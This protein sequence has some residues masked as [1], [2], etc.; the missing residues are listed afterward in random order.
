MLE[1]TIAVSFAIL[2]SFFCSILE[3]ALYAI[4]MGQVEALAE[5]GSRTGRLLK[6]FRT[7]VDAPISAI[8]ALNTV[9]HT[10]GA[11]VAGAAAAEVFGKAWLSTFSLV[12]TLVVLIFSEIIPK[13]AGYVYARRIAPALA[14]R[15]PRR[16]TQHDLSRRSLRWARGPEDGEGALFTYEIVIVVTF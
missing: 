14:L 8:L 12:F 16:M 2:V 9:A 4:P 11:A 1:L 15:G 6:R 10:V 7:D 5:Q 13:T 3:A